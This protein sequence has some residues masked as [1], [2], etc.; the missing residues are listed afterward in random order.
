VREIAFE[1]IPRKPEQTVLYGVVTGQL[2]TFLARRQEQERAVPRFVERE[3]RDYLT[4]GIAEHGF[5]RLH[6]GDCGHDRILPFSCKKRGV[7]PSCGGRRM[8]DTAA[9]LVDRVFPWVPARQWVLSLPFKLRYRMAYDS[10][11]MG[12]ILNIFIRSVFAALRRRAGERFGLKKA[13]CGAVTFV[14]RF[15]SALGLNVHFHSVAFDGVYASGG[16]GVPEF[17]ELPPPEDADVVETVASIAE[18]VGKLIERRGLEEE[19]DALSESDPGLAGLYA[20]AVRG[21]IAAGPNRGDRVAR[22]GADR[23]DGDSLESMSSPRCAALSGFNLHANVGIPARDRERLERLLRYAARPAISLDRLSRLPDGRLLYRLKRMW[24]DGSTDVI[25]EPQD[26]MAKLAALIPAPRVHLVRFH[27]ILGPAAKW[28]PAIVPQPDPILDP[29]FAPPEG[30]ATAPEGLVRP[31]P[32]PLTPRPARRNYAW[33][34]LMMRVFNQPTNC[35]A[36]SRNVRP[37]PDH[38]SIPSAFWAGNR[39]RQSCTAMG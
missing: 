34:L 26:F 2:E 16:D 17:Y 31:G 11:L 33:A 21:R 27:G 18:R 10:G 6:C 29:P 12:D 39:L 19:A 13:Q 23:I 8:A 37:R 4:C 36:C 24:S 30:P 35:I 1:Y 14:Q 15:N 20:A 32:G 38:S 28:R 9:H 3:F 22:L 25:F 5:L 7:C